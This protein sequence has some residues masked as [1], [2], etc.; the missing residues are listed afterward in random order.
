MNWNGERDEKIHFQ[1]LYEYNRIIKE[2]K[3]LQVMI[4]FYVILFAMINFFT[5]RISPHTGDS[6]D[7]N[8]IE[9]TPCKVHTRENIQEKEKKRKGFRK[10][11]K[12]GKVSGRRSNLRQPV[13]GVRV[14]P[15]RRRRQPFSRRSSFSPQSL[16]SLH[17]RRI[18][19]EP[20][21]T[22]SPKWVWES[23]LKMCVPLLIFFRSWYFLKISG[24]LCLREWRC[25]H[26]NGRQNV[27]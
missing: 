9:S 24:E 22:C 2:G 10:E 3:I 15:W 27:F 19:L 16:L 17:G 7:I 21:A 8:I 11:E 14:W 23:G 13:S 18:G 12:E 6:K 26:D 20:A 4:S 25:A 1:T 5:L